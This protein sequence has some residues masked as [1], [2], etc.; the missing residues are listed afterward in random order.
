MQ[1][2]R[3]YLLHKLSYNQFLS[4]IS[5]AWQWGSIREK[6]NGQHSMAHPRNPPPVGLGTKISQKSPTQAELWPILSQISLP[7]QRGSVGEKCNWQHSMAHPWKPLYRCKN[8]LSKP[9]YSPFC[10]IFRC[11]GN[12]GRSGKN[13]IGS[14]RWPIPENPPIG[15]RISYTSQVIANFVPNFVVMATREGPR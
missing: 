2:S 7:R 15:A 8:L 11:H 5:L 12:G 1:K 4:Q 6:C 9:S 13:A 10:P 3:R 14:I